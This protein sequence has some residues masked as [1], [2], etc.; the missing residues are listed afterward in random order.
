MAN[1]ARL[2]VLPSADL[3]VHGC[4]LRLGRNP[5]APAVGVLPAGKIKIGFFR[6]REHTGARED[7]SRK[8]SEA[9]PERSQKSP[10]RKFKSPCS[11]RR[12]G[13]LLLFARWSRRPGGRRRVLAAPSGKSARGE[14]DREGRR[15]R[16]GLHKRV[17][18]V[19]HFEASFVSAAHAF[20]SATNIPY[21]QWLS[22]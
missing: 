12:R 10:A 21:G 2:R 17:Q 3:A 20:A 14:G 18:E 8:P 1:S 16:R 22:L 4:M 9:G 15:D 11:F 7:R 19:G 6:V 13:G 5:S